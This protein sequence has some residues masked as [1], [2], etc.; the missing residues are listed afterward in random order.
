MASD[1]RP[2]EGVS[3]PAAS[4]RGFFISFESIDGLGK[5]TQL[6]LLGKALE[7]AGHE[8]FYAK[9]PGDDVMG[10]KVGA[11]VRNLL[12]KTP[13][14]KQMRPGVADLLFLADHI[15][16]SGDIRDAVT[17]GQVVLC[18]RYADSQFA[19]AASFGKQ[20][21]QWA[22]E[23][24]ANHYGIVP[25]VTVFL[26]ARGPR[27]SDGVEDIAWSLT[28]A[29]ART[30]SEAGKQDGKAWNDV[31][32]QRRVQAAYERYLTGQ[33]RTLIVDVRED[34]DIG[35]IHQTILVD[36]LYRVVHVPR[37]AEDLPSPYSALELTKKVA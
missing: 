14:T 8:V 1:T 21:P 3:A 32:E 34:T 15:Q 2:G 29:K 9:E 22:M 27:L 11:G 28:R 10:S 13:S 12:F 19:Y 6:R 30:G 26:R 25:D 7:D 31:E 37:R 36:I 4:N 23:L 20:C 17:R 5:T 33:P 16:N 24:Y 35:D 18:D